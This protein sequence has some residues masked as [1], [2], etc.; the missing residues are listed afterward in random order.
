MASLYRPQN[1]F[2]LG[3]ITYELLI[4][5]PAVTGNNFLEVFRQIEHFDAAECVATSA[6]NI[7]DAGSGTAA[8]EC[9]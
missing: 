3:L 1:V 7:N 2:V 4:G 9:T 8:S 6:R 5:K